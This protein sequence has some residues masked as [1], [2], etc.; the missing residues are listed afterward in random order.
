[1]AQASEQ[2]EEEAEAV[3]GRITLSVST[4]GERENEWEGRGR[5]REGGEGTGAIFPDKMK[6]HLHSLMPHYL[7][8]FQPLSKDTPVNPLY[9]VA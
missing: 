3:W 6:L 1:M 4:H 2:V 5:T 9:R 7:G 8:Y